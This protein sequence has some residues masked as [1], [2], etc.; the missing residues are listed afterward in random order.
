MKRYILSFLTMFMLSVISSCQRSE[1]NEF[2]QRLSVLNEKINEVS[3]V[4]SENGGGANS[5]E[6][7]N[8]NVAGYFAD[9]IRWELDH[10]ELTKDALARNDLWPGQEKL[11]PE[12][13]NQRYDQHIDRQLTD[14]L[15]LVDKALQMTNQQPVGRAMNEP[16]SWNEMVF[17][18]GYFRVEDRVVFPGGFNIVDRQ[19]VNRDLYPEWTDSDEAESKD[20]LTEMRDMGLGVVGLSIS[21]P[22][23]IT[24]DKTIDQAVVDDKIAELKKFEAL[25]VRVDM[26]LKW[27]G[28]EELLEELWPGITK[29]ASNGVDLDI[30]HPGTFELISIVMS[31]FIPQIIDEPAILSWDMANEPFFDMKGWTDHGMKHFH[32]WLEG[33]HQTIEALNHSWNTD[34]VSFSEIPK[35]KDNP[36]QPEYNP[37]QRTAPPKI[38]PALDYS[39]GQ[40][41]DLITF[42]NYRVARF[43]GI[44]ATEIRHQSPE[45]IIHMK[46]QD[47]NSLGP[48]PFAVADGI[49]REMLTSA[50]NLHGV[51]T[52]PL[53]ETEP[54]MAVIMDSNAPR[55]VLNYDESLYSFHWLGQSFLYD[56]LTSLEP[57]RPIVDMEYHAFSINPIRVPDIGY[58]HA[59]ASLWLAHL[60]GMVA[61]MVWYW[62]QRYGPNPFPSEELKSWFYGSISTQPIVAAEYFQTMNRLNRFSNEIAS[63]AKPSARP[64]RLLVS[65]PSYIQNQKHI[66]SLHRTYEASC[67]H[68]VPLGFVTEKIL[69]NNGLP[70]DTEYLLIADI[71]FLTPESIEI[72][73][74]AKRNGVQLIQI[75]QQGIVDDDFGFPV[76][77]EAISFLEDIPK[78]DYA[79]APDLD[80]Q[81]GEIFQPLIDELLVKVKI[82]NKQNAF[83]VMHRVTMVDGRLVLLI[84]NLRSTPVNIQLFNNQGDVLDG[85]DMLNQKP[86]NGEKISMD[87][88][89]VCLIEIKN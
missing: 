55:A 77:K 48:K 38:I 8:R 31:Q 52:R 82:L 49:D 57:N 24:K 7:I 75:G 9:Y 29:H 39:P 2:E 58:G 27:G 23:L 47:N 66:E 51:D 68:G 25:G 73:R 36:T 17:E 16:I 44:V 67:F 41:Y 61:N 65:K 35:P 10:P 18:D 37:G 21:I 62:H 70:P 30:D 6:V 83:G 19:L 40:W 28:N 59:S 1:H 78:Y 56:Y 88:K 15:K 13:R 43:F 53:P 89:E 45:A 22:Q 5:D 64:I 87:I 84:V 20:F 54:R 71:Q 42:H 12:E 85:F 76:D 60:H 80:K 4:L 34:Y 32:E 26:R 69:A 14:A 11:S 79:T 74:T 3:I 63:L 46:A 50:I 86:V 33:R 72:L 81:L